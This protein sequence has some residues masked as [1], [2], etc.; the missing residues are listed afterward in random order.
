MRYPAA[1]P[2]VTVNLLLLLAAIV[3]AVVFTVVVWD[4]DSKWLGL[5]LAAF[6]ASFVAWG[7][8]P[9]A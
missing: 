6:M 9:P 8:R 3:L 4:S 7:S 2:R 1:M 5:S